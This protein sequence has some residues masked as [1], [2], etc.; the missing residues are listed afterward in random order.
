MKSGIHASASDSDGSCRAPARS[1]L[2]DA[3]HR[4]SALVGVALLGTALA[5]PAAADVFRV[6]FSSGYYYRCT[7]MV[8]FDQRRQ[9]DATHVGFPN[10]G[11]MYCVPTACTNV[12][13][14][15]AHHGY[16]S[17]FIADTT[18]A[19]WQ[20]DLSDYNAAGVSIASLGALMHTD[21][22]EG[23]RSGEGI[24]GLRAMLDV[25]DIPIT[26]FEIHQ[27]GGYTP[28][29]DTIAAF[30]MTGALC[31]PAVGRYGTLPDGSILR[32]GGHVVTLTQLYKSGDTRIIKFKDPASNEDPNNLLAQASFRNG[33]YSVE[34]H[35]VVAFG[36][37]VRIQDKIVGYGSHW[38]DG[39]YVFATQYGA[40]HYFG[41]RAG[42]LG[43][44]RLVRPYLIDGDNQPPAQDFPIDGTILNLALCPHAP[45]IVY[46]R[47]PMQIRSNQL[48]RL[49]TLTGATTCGPFVDQATVMVVGRNRLVYV[50]VNDRI[51]A[52]DLDTEPAALVTEGDVAPATRAIAYDDQTDEIVCV[53]DVERS[54]RRLDARDLGMVR[55][56][57]LLP[58]AVQL[59]QDVTVAILP[60]N[61]DLLLSSSAA[62]TVYQVFLGAPGS[63]YGLRSQIVDPA[64]VHVT[65]VEVDD[66]GAA[67]VTA[68]GVLR[69]YVRNANQIWERQTASR[70][71][72]LEVDELF[73]IARSRTNHNPATMTPE[74]YR[75]VLPTEF[76]EEPPQMLGDLNC[77]GSVN[78]FDIEPFVLGLADPAG[79]GLVYPG[80]NPLNGDINDDG[81]FNNFDIEHFVECIARG[82]CR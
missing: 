70:F 80:C 75:N 58:G 14:Y 35:L 49:N 26:V 18:Y 55:S 82:G 30:A 73:R 27:D 22:E 60:D 51:L 52:F 48:C 66:R 41:G 54:I 24:E 4:R 31:V 23:T 39:V 46:V 36:G 72:G 62:N 67:L 9:A 34:D 53:S 63:V 10:N 76:I 5:A 43:G 20:S 50:V 6:F 16:S 12:L 40:Y 19:D 56:E 64:L 47:R 65:S 68:D 81:L 7:N 61:G 21:A 45:D 57:G 37:Y 29:M 78:N 2:D 11:S 69:R 59:D 71:E 32:T 28:R 33:R 1:A 79:Y 13:A 42:E 3:K 17:G 8:D 15:L 74:A 25:F 38:I 77:D 44:I